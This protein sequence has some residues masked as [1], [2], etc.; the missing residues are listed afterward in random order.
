[1][2]QKTEA[3]T[4]KTMQTTKRKQKA[5]NWSVNIKEK[6]KKENGLS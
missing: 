2:K 6:N 4:T 1:M 3:S 5:D